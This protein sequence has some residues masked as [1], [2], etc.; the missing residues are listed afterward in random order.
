MVFPNFECFLTLNRNED[1]TSR[2][3]FEYDS[4]GTSRAVEI[5]KDDPKGKGPVVESTDGYLHV[6]YF[7]LILK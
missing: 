4:K 1:T 5:V 2:I 7:L 3:V 6:C